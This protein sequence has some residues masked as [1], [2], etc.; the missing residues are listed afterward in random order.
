MKGQFLL[1]SDIH[2]DD[3]AKFS[4]V[5]PVTG[6]GTRLKNCL[7]IFDQI[8]EYGEAH[9]IDTLLVGGDI[10]DK[11]GYI[12]VPVYVSVYDK[13][14]HFFENGWRVYSIVGNHDQATRSGAFDSLKPL[15]MTCRIEGRGF[16][17]SVAERYKV[18]FVSFCEFPKTFLE[19]LQ[20]VAKQ[21]PDI[22]LI[23]QGINGALIAGDEIL[24]RDEVSLGEILDIVGRDAWVFSG[25]YHIHQTLAPKVCFIGSA[26]PKDFGDKTAKGFLHFDG[27]GFKQIESR[28]PKFIEVEADNLASQEFRKALAG[29]YVKVNYKGQEPPGVEKMGF[30]G[31]V[32]SKAVDDEDKGETRDRIDPSH[33][34]TKIIS[35]YLDVL[36]RDGK[37]AIPRA[38]L[39]QCL[40]D[41]TEGKSLDQVVGSHSVW[42][43]S[44]EIE[45]FLSYENAEVFFDNFSGVVA[46]NGENRDDPSA[47]SNGSGKSTIPEALKW[48]LF[49]KTLRGLTGDDVVNNRVG[50]DCKVGFHFMIGKDSY[51]V[52]RYRKHHAHKN[53]LFF[54]QELDDYQL[55][56][57][58]KS[59]AE[60]QDK[61]LKTLGIDELTFDNTVF[62]GQG[63]NN[64]FASLTDKEQKAIL[65]N[66]LGM[67]A[68]FDI[69]ERAKE[70]A[71]GFR[72]EYESAASLLSN[73]SAT[74]EREEQALA[75]SSKKFEAH[76]Q[77]LKHEVQNLRDEIKE[78]KDVLATVPNFDAEEAEL[79]R[80]RLSLEELNGDDELKEMSQEYAE[81][82]DSLR[83]AA[84]TIARLDSQL[85][86]RRD[87]AKRLSADALKADEELQAIRN[88]KCPLCLQ[89]LSETEHKKKLLEEK[90]EARRALAVKIE[91]LTLEGENISR[92]LEEIIPLRDE[93][94]ERE[95][96][97]LREI[98]ELRDELSKVKI[99]AV[100]EYE[101]KKH[102][103]EALKRS[104]SQNGM[105]LKRLESDLKDKLSSANPHAEYVSR[106][107]QRIAE[108]HA[109]RVAQ[110]KLKRES[111]AAYCSYKFW[112]NAF[113]DKGTIEEP[114]LKT[115]LFESVVPVLD[116]LAH[117]FSEKMTSG[118]IEVR[119]STVSRLK[120]GECR[121]KFNVSVVNKFGASSYLGDSGG[122][123]RKVDIIVMFALHALA[124]IRSGSKFDVL[125]MDEVLDYLDKEGC[126]RVMSLL[127]EMK[128]DIPKIF[129]ISHNENLKGY[130]S[131]SLDVVKEGG[132]SRIEKAA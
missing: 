28:A 89:S 20:E 13:F 75:L 72:K 65:E 74:V 87:D 103:L 35:S 42:V 80:L 36:E 22:Y 16:C 95:K 99:N 97:L 124:R 23:H 85:K 121:D 118:S 131:S 93:L 14:Q 126:E 46:I 106:G 26:V 3:Y 91:A 54:F 47:L 110:E 84:H 90:A 114:P 81:T 39:L 123:R 1:V 61:I 66:I 38:E 40:A 108:V 69:Y 101:S 125:F 88:S 116:E 34:P 79:E 111:Y 117:R 107:K 12:S 31:W 63:L 115:F 4:K 5:D 105:R 78:L 120:N 27:K 49:G 53:Q 45:N 51:D 64:A 24:A 104:V 37:L 8:Y 119:F 92:D 132:V 86:A 82:R 71:A 77:N 130:F 48:V 73:I 41:L 128:K 55:D 58:G 122:E 96:S 21:K 9:G 60:T 19:N 43:G 50:K 98:S 113:S 62:F 129:V 25:H 102:E 83:D 10:F 30:E 44:I 29:H 70:I 17:S 127:W 59:D 32:T 52:Y 7:D 68:F 6:L 11:R 67:G 76:E 18:G 112:E 33:S 2:V 94:L 109:E 15:P 100:K 56:L 57:R